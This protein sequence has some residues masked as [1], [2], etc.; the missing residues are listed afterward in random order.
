MACMRHIPGTAGRR[1]RRK[2]ARAGF[3]LIELLVAIVIF[4]TVMSGVT[5]LFSGAIRASKQG[6]QNQDA[7]EVARGA[8]DII[9]RDLNRSFTS[10][11]HGDVFNFYGT[12]IGFTFVGMVSADESSNP[13]LA[14]VTYV[15]H[16]SAA[17]QR[18]EAVPFDDDDDIRRETF[19]LLRLI[20]PGGEDLESFPVDWD[21]IGGGWALVD[22][23]SGV[24]TLQDLIQNEVSSAETR[25]TCDQGDISC[26]Q[27][28]E[29]AK[30]RELWIRMLS[31]E[32]AGV[33]G[34]PD[35]WPLLGPD[36]DED[37]W[38][39]GLD[40]EDFVVAENIL[41]VDHSTGE[42][43][44]DTVPLIDSDHVAH[45]SDPNGPFPE[46][47]FFTYR[48]FGTTLANRVGLNEGKIVV[49]IDFFFWNDRRNIEF[50]Q[51]REGQILSDGADNDG[52][53]YIDEADEANGINF[54]SP[55]DA[56][57]PIEIT[58]NFT[59]FFPSPY[60]GAPDFNR[61]FTMRI[62]LPTGYRRTF[63]TPVAP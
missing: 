12:P 55:L 17:W 42:P 25:G 53:S 26:F 51:F 52:D 6:F 62:D 9:E 23:P 40:P 32:V 29:R 61:K 13:N 3:S 30:K 27:E 60:A 14:R 1:P 49:P 35:I 20:E 15:I 31:G 16:Q 59:L 28:I 18:L 57:A 58:M 46:S 36:R 47:V 34:L 4:I 21:N 24:S 41:N 2:R 48:D 37:G 44:V 7:F 22:P 5:L 19:A 38:P 45:A 43:L 63:D 50:M 33:D 39:D 56:R 54:G 8:M 10:R 11:D